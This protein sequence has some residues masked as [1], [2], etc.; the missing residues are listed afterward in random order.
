MSYSYRVTVTRSVKETVK[1]KDES[2]NKITLTEIL[3]QGRMKDLLTD[4]LEKKGFEKQADGTWKRTV[5]GVTE[6]FDPKSMEVTATAEVSG[7][8]E[9]E[10]S[11]QA[12]G[13]AR[14]EKEV[15]S[16]RSHAEREVGARLEKELKVTDAERKVKQEQLV[17]EARKRL[18]ESEGRRMKEL[19][20]ATLDV[21]AEAIKE[22]AKTL[23]EVKEQKESRRDNGMGGQEYE[24]I[25]KVEDNG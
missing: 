6:T 22:K 24:L 25:I 23:G 12:I 14:R 4:A 17:Q 3:P 8:I 11:V 15:G 9:K 21:Y 19:N 13:D 20:E 1:G 2:R 7:N 5:D 18:E 10:K 16:Q